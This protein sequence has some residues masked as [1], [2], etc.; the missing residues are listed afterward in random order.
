MNSNGNI[1]Y[2]DGQNLYL[3]TAKSTP[4]WHIDLARFRR[5]LAE[6]YNVVVAYYYLGYIQ[7]GEEYNKLYKTIRQAGF[8]LM[9]REHNSAMLG[10]KK[11]NVDSDIIFN[12]MK[13]LYLNEPFEK[14]ILMSGG[15]RL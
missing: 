13:Q 15:W 9:F 10:T 7:T 11:G 2:I 1:A 14:I 6:K 12:A 4:K 3:S 8:S 5:Y